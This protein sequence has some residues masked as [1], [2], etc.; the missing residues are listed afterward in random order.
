[1]AR[2]RFILARPL[3]TWVIGL[4]SAVILFH[5]A[6][7]TL[8]VL[9]ASSGPWPLKVP[10][11]GESPATPPQFAQRAGSL[12]TAFYLQ[13]L[14]LTQNYHFRT[15]DPEVQGVYLE[16]RLK[17][18]KKNLMKTLRFPDPEA[19]FWVRHRQALLVQWLA[20]DLPIR[21]PQGDVI[22]AVGKDAPGVTIWSPEPGRP[23]DPK[24][25]L[26]RLEEVKIHKIPREREVMRPSELSLALA[27]S[28]ARYLCREHGAAQAELIR[29][30][31]YPI[32]PVVMVYANQL[33]PEADLPPET[34]HE[35]ISNF[36]ELS[37]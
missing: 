6:L 27:R 22:E 35:L 13:P 5:L 9:Y 29:H 23:P 24:K 1:M 15:N 36:G 11:F 34:F 2:A 20:M 12:A 16:V 3:P 19:N 18:A 8:L 32:M 37:R 21:P 14:K 28:Y 33:P 10:P 25:T 30:T 4:G 17:D 26:L 31:R 7:V